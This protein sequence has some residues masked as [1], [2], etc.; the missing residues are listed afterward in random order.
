[1]HQTF[2]EY[3]EQEIPENLAQNVMER[4]RSEESS[5]VTPTTAPKRLQTKTKVLPFW[6]GGSAK[7]L[8]SIAACAVV[9]VGLWR[10]TSPA[11]KLSQ[12]E[13]ALYGTSTA[14]STSSALPVTQKAFLS[15]TA[16]ETHF[17]TQNE[18]SMPSKDEITSMVSDTLKKAPGTIFVL[19][20]IPEGLEGTA[21]T[22]QNGDDILVPESSDLTQL[23]AQLPS[24]LMEISGTDG[25]V[26]LLVLK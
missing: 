11:E 7:V 26:V 13:A 5:A 21:Y 2:S 6:R 1:M 18:P 20:A 17:H 22:T 3:E 15:D 24:P 23:L 10:F 16:S 4:I 25:P 9:C 8:T 14:D 19:E 12:P